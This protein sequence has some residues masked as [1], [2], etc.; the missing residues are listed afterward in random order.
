MRELN[1]LVT[2]R[3][4]T[5]SS[6]AT[7]HASG[8]SQLWM[9]CAKLTARDIDSHMESGEREDAATRMAILGYSVGAM[10]HFPNGRHTLQA[11]RQLVHEYAIY[12][13][14]KNRDTVRPAAAR[15]TPAAAPQLT[16]SLPAQIRFEEGSFHAALPED[17]S[18]PLPS[19]S[20]R[21][22]GDAI[23]LQVLRL[24]A[25]AL[26]LDY[27]HVA[28]AFC[29]TLAQLYAKLLDES[30]ARCEASGVALER[31]DAG[32]VVRACGR[33]WAE[34]EEGGLGGEG[35]RGLHP[36]SPSLRPQKLAIRRVLDTLYGAASSVL[37]HDVAAVDDLAQPFQ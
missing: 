27:C 20:L 1:A 15:P 9:R 28:T 29:R 10:L 36:A 12:C 23:V 4:E 30:V 34:V 24:P 16:A 33:S 37:Q 17:P 7:V 5:L 8:G 31:L 22:D 18:A 3:M 25:L 19:P 32:L 35:C 6:L 21:R 13:E 2:S 26:Q 14:G 11:A